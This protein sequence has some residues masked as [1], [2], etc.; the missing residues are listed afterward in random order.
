MYPYA[1]DGRIAVPA[2][3]D[4]LDPLVGLGFLAAVTR[5][6]RLATGILL[7]A[8]H[9]PV[10]VAKQAA[11]LDVV[12]GGRLGLGVGIGWSAE[13]YAALGVPF[14]R[15]AARTAEY[16]RVLRTI[17]AHD[18]VAFSGEFVQIADARIYPK[19]FGGRQVPVILGGNSDPALRRVAAYGDGWYG[20]N[21]TMDEVR[22]RVPHLRALWGEAGRT[23]RPEVVVALTDAGPEVA[24]ELAA[25]GV[26]EVV[27]VAA[28][29]PDPVAAG[30]WV[31]AL[32]VPWRLGTSRRR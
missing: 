12:S 14:A 13:E 30:A 6:I 5:R 25:L 22:T 3:A 20:F 19:P 8:E 24:D 17:W 2:D 7:L 4:W 31:E 18:V 23:G 9:N 29:P 32:G 1:A 15:R 10:L 21:L 26:D 11:T 28:P 16:V 27:L